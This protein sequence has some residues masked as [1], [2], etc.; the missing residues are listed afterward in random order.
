MKIVTNIS[1]EKIQ[2]NSKTLKELE[3]VHNKYMKRQQVC[4]TSI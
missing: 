2:D 4:I 1:R 3:S